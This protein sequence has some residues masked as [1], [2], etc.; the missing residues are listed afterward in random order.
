MAPRPKKLS[1]AQVRLVRRLVE[2]CGLRIADLA[3]R[4]NVAEGT[5]RRE[6]RGTGG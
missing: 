4:F 3:R 1:R 6:L 5:L 2:K